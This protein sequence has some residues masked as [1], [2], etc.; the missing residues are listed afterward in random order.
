M[1]LICRTCAAAVT[2]LERVVV[3]RNPDDGFSLYEYRC[4]CGYGGVGGDPAVVASLLAAGVRV[5][6]LERV[7]APPPE[8]TAV[9]E[10]RAL[11]DRDDFLAALVREGD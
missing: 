4:P 9:A 5:I 7:D 8:E 10:L 3:Y 6:R 11:L 2:A 1:S